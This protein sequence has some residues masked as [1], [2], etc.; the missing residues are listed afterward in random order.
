MK[1]KALR[2]KIARLEAGLV[3]QNEHLAEL[4]RRLPPEEVKDTSWPGRTAAC[5]FPSFSGA[6]RT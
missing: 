2:K 1:T 4:K 5:G 3:E 6:R